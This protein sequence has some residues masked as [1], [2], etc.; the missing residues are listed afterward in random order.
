MYNSYNKAS[1]D[2]GKL[3]K[4]GFCDAFITAAPFDMKGFSFFP[5][6]INDPNNNIFK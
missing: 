6:R 3:K 4:A 5:E 2:L 1:I